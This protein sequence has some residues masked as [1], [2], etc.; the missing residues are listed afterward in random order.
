VINI[1]Q[2][3]INRADGTTQ[4][5]DEDKD[6]LLFVWWYDFLDWLALRKSKKQSPKGITYNA[7]YRNVCKELGLKNRKCVY[8]NLEYRVALTCMLE[9]QNQWEKEQ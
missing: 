2:W 1:T 8:E 5:Y 3:L 7:I 9:V 6:S 4:L